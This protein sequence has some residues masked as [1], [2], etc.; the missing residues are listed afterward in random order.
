MKDIDIV[1]P[2]VDNTDSVWR[3]IYKE[4]CIKFFRIENKYL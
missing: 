2:F 4:F 3:E 1:V